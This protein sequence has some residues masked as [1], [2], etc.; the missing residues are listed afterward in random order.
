MSNHFFIF[1]SQGLI[2]PKGEKGEYGDIGPPG[3]MGPPGLPGPPG[4]PG[5]KGEKGEKGDS[6]S[7]SLLSVLQNFLPG[8]SLYLLCNNE[9]KCCW[10]NIQG[11][12]QVTVIGVHRTY[13]GYKKINYQDISLVF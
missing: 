11:N 4:Y 10:F 13:L 12:S 3:L 6:V 8:Y 5:Q 7:V 2:G 9:I 1:N